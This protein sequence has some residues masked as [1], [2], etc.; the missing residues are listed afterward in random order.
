MYEEFKTVVILKQQMRCTDPE[1]PDFSTYDMG[2]CRNGISTSCAPKPRRASHC[3]HFAIG[4]SVITA[5]RNESHRKSLTNV[6]MHHVLTVY[7]ISC[8]LYD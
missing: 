3:R 2:E 8:T 7:T 1:W 6:P 5:T 4:K